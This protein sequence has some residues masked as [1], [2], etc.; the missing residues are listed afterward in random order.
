MYIRKRLVYSEQRRPS[1]SNKEKNARSTGIFV[2]KHFA[3]GQQ[4]AQSQY[5]FD[6]DQAPAAIP[7][8]RGGRSMLEGD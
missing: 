2:I 8:S 5:M 3:S 4:R 6:G 1:H 7:Y